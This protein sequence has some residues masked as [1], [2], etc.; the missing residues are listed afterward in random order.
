MSPA[1]RSAIGEMVWGTFEHLGN[2]PSAAYSY[3]STTGPKTVPQN[4]AGTWLFTPNGAGQPFNLTH[5][6]WDEPTGAIVG[7]PAGS[8]VTPTPV[9]RTNPWGMP[10][11]SAG[12]NTQI[13]GVNASAIAQLI[14]G[15]IRRNYFQLG[16]TWTINGQAPNNFNQVGT[17]HLANATIETFVQAD[18]FSSPPNPGLNCFSCHGTNSV[19]VSHV[20]TDL[21]P[22]F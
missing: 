7:V 2:A 3:N 13:I 21:K 16:T 22:L 19:L 1:A 6:S 10:G 8:P 18:P 15:D 4:T 11:A 9:L 14:G 20:Y 12:S 5:A 17:N